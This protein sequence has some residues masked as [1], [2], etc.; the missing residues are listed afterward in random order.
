MHAVGFQARTPFSAPR[1]KKICMGWLPRN[2]SE[3]EEGQ[4]KKISSRRLL[5]GRPTPLR[6]RAKR[7]RN[8]RLARA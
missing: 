2:L 8:D 3:A 5:S 7:G 1:N 6:S 4:P